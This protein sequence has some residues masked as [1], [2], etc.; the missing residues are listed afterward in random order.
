MSLEHILV[1][2]RLP[3]GAHVEQVNKEVVGQRLRTLG[4]DAVL[5][6]TD[7]CAQDAHAADEDRHLGRGQRQQLRL[8]D[9]ELF[10]RY[11]VFGLEVIAKPSA[12]GSR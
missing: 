7:V 6:L 9:E 5:G 8:V 4:E 10:S 1:R 12:T 11:G 2:G 3:L